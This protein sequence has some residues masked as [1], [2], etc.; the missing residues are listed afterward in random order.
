VLFSIVVH[1]GLTRRTADNDD[2]CK[3]ER[4][5]KEEAL[6][7]NICSATTKATVLRVKSSRM[8]MALETLVCADV[9]EKFTISS[10]RDDGRWRLFGW[11]MLLEGVE[12]ERKS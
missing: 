5:R 4:I 6:M 11:A 1:F 12:A 2:G 7:L 8:E 9:G 3:A 10:K